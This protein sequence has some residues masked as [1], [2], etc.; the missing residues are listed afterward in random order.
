MSGL[1]WFVLPDGQAAFRGRNR[2]V[3]SGSRAGKLHA[4]FDERG[5]ETGHGLNNEAPANE[6]AGNR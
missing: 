1:V 2:D 4:R 5:V 6:R 3:S